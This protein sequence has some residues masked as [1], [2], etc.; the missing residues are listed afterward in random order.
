MKG[1]A[2]F[3]MM[4]RQPTLRTQLLYYKSSLGVASLAIAITSPYSA[5]LFLWEFIKERMNSNN[6]Q[7]LEVLKLNI[8]HIVAN[9]DPETLRKITRNTLKGWMLVFEKVVGIFSICC[10]AVV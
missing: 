9:N 4:R 8:Q 5:R 3:N 6:P 1:T 7:S 10:K 2:G